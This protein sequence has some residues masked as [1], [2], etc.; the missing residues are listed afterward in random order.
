[1]REHWLNC[2]N[3]SGT[4][5]LYYQEWGNPN[6][7]EVII[8]VHGLTRNSHDFDF[9]AERLHHQFRVICPDL[10]GR[11]K[12][13]HLSSPEHYCIEQ[14]LQDLN[15]LLD[16]VNTEQVHWLG[17]SLGGLL[18]IALTAQDPQRIKSLILNDIGPY[19]HQ[20]AVTQIAAALHAE[21]ALPSKAALSAFQKLIYQDLGDQSASFWEHLTENDHIALPDGKF[22]RNYDRKIIDGLRHEQVD[23]DKLWHA[24]LTINCPIYVLRGADSP[25]FSKELLEKMLASKNAIE[26]TEFP[27]I[28]HPVSLAPTHEIE[29][30]LDWLERRLASTGALV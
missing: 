28:G 18:G 5:Q 7:P 2:H 9:I 30:V 25:L 21:P 27:G 3:P 6:N 16:Y 13:G 22:R 1:M 23:N 26:A 10:P 19:L 24:W 12:S 14:Y 20:E 4:H 29:P 15:Q 8:C 17:T 11:G